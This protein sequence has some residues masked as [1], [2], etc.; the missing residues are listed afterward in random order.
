[1][2]RKYKSQDPKQHSDLYTDE[3]PRGTIKGLGFVDSAKAR[4]SVNKI[5][6]SGKEYG[7]FFSGKSQARTVSLDK[8]V[9][10]NRSQEI[11][12][13]IK[14]INKEGQVIREIIEVKPHKQLFPPKEPKRKSKR[15]FSEV[16]TYIINQ[17]KFSAAREYCEDRKLK[18]RILTEK[19]ILPRK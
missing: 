10:L 5:K 14:Y 11:Y 4:Q 15:F 16:T 6:N 12:N 19:E 9:R 17:A 1:M 18:F 13:Y 8:P 3:N 2:P 7:V